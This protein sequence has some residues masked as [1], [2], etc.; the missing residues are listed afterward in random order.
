MA[1]VILSV[2]YRWWVK[3]YLKLAVCFAFVTFPFM[4]PLQALFW[5]EALIQSVNDFIIKYGVVIK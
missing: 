2:Q 5:R 3:W 1:H 4:D